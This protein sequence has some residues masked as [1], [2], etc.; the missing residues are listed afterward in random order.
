MILLP[1]G[2]IH[3]TK[4]DDPTAEKIVVGI[5][6]RMIADEQDE[7]RGLLLPLLS[8]GIEQYCIFRNLKA[9]GAD[10]YLRNLSKINRAS[11]VAGLRSWAE[12]MQL[13]AWLY[14]RW[15][16]WGFVGPEPVRG[17]MVL[18]IQNRL[19][20]DFVNAPTAKEMAAALNVSYSYMCR[21]LRETLRMNYCD[22]LN[23]ARVEGARKLLL[24]TEKSITEIGLDCGFCDAAYFIKIFKRFTGE[25]PRRYRTFR[26]GET[27]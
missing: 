20:K 17:G 10:W 1:P 6:E 27:G 3:C 22:L 13:Y 16:E 26:N 7:E 23:H 19:R 18:K 12:I 9:G 21:V 2:R 15:M 4:C 5:D 24:T 8:S 14:E 25:T 11:P